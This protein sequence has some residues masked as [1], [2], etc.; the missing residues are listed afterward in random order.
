MTANL[1]YLFQ[2][3]VYGEV[4]KAPKTISFVCEKSWIG[5]N[6]R[7]HYEEI[8]LIADDKKLNLLFI[9]PIGIKNE[10]L[11][12]FLMLN[13]LGNQ[14]V[15]N[16]RNI[17]ISEHDQRS[18]TGKHKNRFNIE[19]LIE[20]GYGFVTLHQSDIT[21]DNKELNPDGCVIAKWAGGLSIAA[22]F[23]KAHQNIKDVIVTGFSRRGKAALL[24]GAFNH[25]SINAVIAH[26]SG[27]GGVAP[28]INKG[29]FSETVR[30]I[31]MRYPHWFNEK[32]KSYNNTPQNIPVNS[33][34]LLSLIAPRPVLISNGS[35][36]FWSDP[37]GTR[38]SVNLANKKTSNDYVTCKTRFGGHSLKAKDW[39]TFTAFL[40]KNLP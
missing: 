13:A 18:S 2:E 28:Y 10:D 32:F 12:S 40:Q 4:P 20:Q 16:D 15:I 1:K 23:L 6:G 17:T 24:A 19:H 11:Q 29:L 3:H 25:Q 22:D 39:L 37:Y 9:K 26:Q 5:M 34:D 38:H 30:Q 33:S 31:N 14:S 35:L 27:T 36:D 21:P 7:A 8:T